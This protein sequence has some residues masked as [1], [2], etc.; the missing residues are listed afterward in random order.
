VLCCSI[1]PRLQHF[2]ANVNRVRPVVWGRLSGPRSLRRTRTGTLV[3]DL[4][5]R[6]VAPVGGH[7]RSAP[8]LPPPADP[9]LVGSRRSLVRRRLAAGFADVSFAI[10]VLLDVEDSVIIVVDGDARLRC[11][12]FRLGRRSNRLRGVADVSDRVAGWGRLHVGD[13]SLI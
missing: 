10:I 4:L 12:Y 8:R 5:D 6:R 2:D 9:S 3:A 1:V 7:R 11:C 13:V